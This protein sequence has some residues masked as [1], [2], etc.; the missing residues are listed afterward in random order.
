MFGYVFYK[1]YVVDDGEWV[2]IVEFE[3]EEVFYWWWIDF[4]Y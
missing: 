4:E 2:M 1:G 3:F